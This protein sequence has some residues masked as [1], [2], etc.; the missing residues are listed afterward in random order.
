MDVLAA[1]E[2]ALSP[3]E[4]HRR[5]ENSRVAGSPIHNDLRRASN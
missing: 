1:A 5:A 3:P 4:V 2:V